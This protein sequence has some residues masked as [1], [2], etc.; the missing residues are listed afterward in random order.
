MRKILGTGTDTETRVGRGEDAGEPESA[1]ADYFNVLPEGCIAHIASLTTPRDACRL[2][3]V[4]SIFR[5]AADSDA[6]WERFLPPDCLSVVSPSPSCP[7]K[8]DLYLSLSDRF[9]LIDRGTK[10]ISP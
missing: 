7:S 10:V 3:L 6:V 2:C 9:V 8:K 5:S 1:A 4:S